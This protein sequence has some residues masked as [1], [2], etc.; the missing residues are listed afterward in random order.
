MESWK[1]FGTTVSVENDLL[2]RHAVSL[3]HG[4]GG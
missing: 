3:E 4:V 1:P 2:K